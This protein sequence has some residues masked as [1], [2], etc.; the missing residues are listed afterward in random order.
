MFAFESLQQ[1]R[2]CQNIEEHV[3][4]AKVYQWKRI[5]PV[6]C[7]NKTVSMPVKVVITGIQG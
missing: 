3:K 7:H 5:Y 4:E 2:E 6:R 1:R